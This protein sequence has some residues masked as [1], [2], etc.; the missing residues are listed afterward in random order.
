MRQIHD[1][2]DGVAKEETFAPDHLTDRNQIFVFKLHLDR[3]I[4]GDH[5][6]CVASHFLDDAE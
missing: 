5:L 4:D 6:V 3:L 2:L 1:Q